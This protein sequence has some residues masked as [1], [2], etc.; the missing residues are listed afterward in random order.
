MAG[1]HNLSDDDK[2][3]IGQKIPLQKKLD[4]LVETALRKGEDQNRPDL[5]LL[6]LSQYVNRAKVAVKNEEAWVSIIDELIQEVQ[7]GKI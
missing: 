7:D 1:V 6:V 4:K 5:H 3:R 2:R